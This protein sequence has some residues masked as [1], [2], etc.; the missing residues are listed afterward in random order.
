MKFTREELGTVLAALRFWQSQGMADDPSIRPNGLHEIAT[1]CDKLTSLCGDDIDELCERLNDGEHLVDHT[2]LTC[3]HCKQL[4]EKGEEVESTSDGTMHSQ[5]AR[6]HEQGED[7]E[8]TALDEQ[9]RAKIKEMDKLMSDV[10]FGATDTEPQAEWQF[11]LVQAAA[12]GHIKV[13]Q[14][15]NGWQIYSSQAGSERAAHKLTEKATEICKWI[16][17][18]NTDGS[19]NELVKGECWRIT[20]P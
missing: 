15:A 16:C 8:D 18:H 6:L 19:L 4:I 9:L 17:E 20:W 10:G 7:A 12:R 2:K 13:P 3:G 11:A 1:D 5:C 14:T